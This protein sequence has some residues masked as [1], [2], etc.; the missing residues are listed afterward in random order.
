MHRHLA[1]VRGG[2]ISPLPD[3][4]TQKLESRKYQP[5]ARC[6]FLDLL[7]IVGTPYLFKGDDFTGNFSCRRLCPFTFMVKVQV[8]GLTE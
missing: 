8:A 5:V 3:Q 6:Y 2:S 7:A 1:L 4:D